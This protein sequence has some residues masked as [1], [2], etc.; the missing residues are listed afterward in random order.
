MP[1]DATQIRERLRLQRIKDE[2]LISELRAND[3]RTSDGAETFVIITTTGAKTGRTHVKPLCVRVYGADLI[4]AGTAGGQPN[5][6]QWYLNLVVHPALTVEH[7][8]ET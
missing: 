2:A 8:G 7:L 1:L 3:G 6:T 4:I 5:H